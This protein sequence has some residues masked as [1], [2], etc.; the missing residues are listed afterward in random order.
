MAKIKECPTACNLG[1]FPFVCY[2]LP[3]RR[4]VILHC[5]AM[6]LCFQRFL[7]FA[8][9]NIKFL[10]FLSRK[11]IYQSVFCETAGFLLTD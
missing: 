3:H 10:S 4:S 8:S 1:C 6:I 5:N 7:A 2:V 11:D 9:D